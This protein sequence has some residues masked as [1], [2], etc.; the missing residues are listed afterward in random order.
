MYHTQNEHWPEWNAA[1]QK[2]LIDRQQTDGPLAGSWDPDSTW[3]SY[4]GRIYSTAI[5]ALSL[6]VYYRYLP[7]FKDGQ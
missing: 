7:I 2:Q 4:G 1:I 6:E 3:G 5:G